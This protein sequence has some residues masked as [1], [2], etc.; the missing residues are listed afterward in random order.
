[1]NQFFK[2]TLLNEA[3][4]TFRK[5]G[6]LLLLIS[7]EPFGEIVAMIDLLNKFAQLLMNDFALI[8]YCD[9]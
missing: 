3:S 1:M 7:S 5:A 4:M 2:L 6:F 8:D 9:E